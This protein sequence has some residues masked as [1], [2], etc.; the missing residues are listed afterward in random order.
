MSA[1]EYPLGWPEQRAVRI[2]VWMA[3]LTKRSEERAPGFGSTFYAE[4]LR[5]YWRIVMERP[6]DKYSRS[7]HAFLDPAT[8][9][10][11]KSAGWKAPAKGARFNLRDDDSFDALIES[12]DPYGSYLY[13][14]ATS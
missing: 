14:S 8:G 1:A 9:D 4:H 12:C 13:A 11:F 10:V 2:N 5:K 7:V 3:V 6:G